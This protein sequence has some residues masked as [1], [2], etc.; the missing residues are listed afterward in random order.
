[1]TATI[2]PAVEAATRRVLNLRLD[3]LGGGGYP[4]IAVMNITLHGDIAGTFAHPFPSVDRFYEWLHSETTDSPMNGLEEYGFDG[5]AD[6][7][8]VEVVVRPVTDAPGEF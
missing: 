6:H 4:V 5:P 1:M 2:D 7:Y 3:V 8:N